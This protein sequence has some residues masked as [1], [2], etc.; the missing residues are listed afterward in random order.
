[1]IEFA[2][3]CNSE[4]YS[5]LRFLIFLILFIYFFFFSVCL[6]GGLCVVQIDFEILRGIVVFDCGEVSDNL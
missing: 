3:T 2:M 6:L 5:R 1:M 4:F